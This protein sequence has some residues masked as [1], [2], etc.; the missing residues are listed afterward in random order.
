[1]FKRNKELR[2]KVKELD[3]RV[4]LISESRVTLGTRLTDSEI[5]VQLLE[6]KLRAMNDELARLATNQ[7]LVREGLLKSLNHCTTVVPK[8]S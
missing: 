1:M 8:E 6:Q 4:D 3:R 7:T 2:D 5:K